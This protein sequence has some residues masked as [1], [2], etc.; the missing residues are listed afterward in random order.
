MTIIFEELGKYGRTGNMMFQCA[1]VIGAAKS[2]NDNWFIPIVPDFQKLNIPAE[3]N[4]CPDFKPGV[5]AHYNEPHFHYTPIP[6]IGDVTNIKG[7]FQSEKFFEHCKD[8]VR[9]ILSPKQ[10]Y[11]HSSFTAIHVRRTDYLTHKDCYHILT[12]DNYYNKAMEIVPGPYLIFSDDIEWCKS[13][14]VGDDFSFSDERDPITD[15]AHMIG[16]SR[17][18]IANSSFSWWGAWLNPNP[19][20]VVI[21]PSKWFGPKLAPSHNTKDLI[22]DEWFKISS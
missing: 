17:F 1:S 22:P 20:K 19:D 5:V 10:K 18:I 21:A 3:S 13:Q 6:K 7:Y 16:C 4:G 8:E 9:S 12:R 15:L 11:D 14:F 2:H